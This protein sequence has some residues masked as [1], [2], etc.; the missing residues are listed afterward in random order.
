VEIF[1]RHV[2]RIDLALFDVI[3]PKK[4]GKQACD[5]LRKLDPSIKV[6]LLS[7]YTADMIESRGGLVDGVDLIMKPVQPME[8]ARRVREMLDR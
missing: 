2:G 1:S 3:M 5:E 7:G 8:L 6:L 4:S